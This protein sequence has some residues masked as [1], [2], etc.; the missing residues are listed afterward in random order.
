MFIH[1]LL[2]WQEPHRNMTEQAA[3]TWVFSKGKPARSWF[4]GAG[5]SDR[6][7]SPV[8]VKHTH[9]AGE[10]W[11][12]K[13][14]DTKS[15]LWVGKVNY[16]QQGNMMEQVQHSGLMVVSV[17]SWHANDL[18]GLVP[19]IASFPQS[20]SSPC[21]THTQLESPAGH[22]TEVCMFLCVGGC[23]GCQGHT[24]RAVPLV[25]CQSVSQSVSPLSSRWDPS[26]GTGGDNGSELM[27]HGG[28]EDLR[29]W[30]EKGV[31]WSNVQQVWSWTSQLFEADRRN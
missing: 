16:E 23:F 9:T 24:C 13:L 5:L 7:V 17:W 3:Q 22:V 12:G 30:P 20:N 19:M 8:K 25:R 6:L 28:S 2:F 18:E 29:G 27:R 11:Y 4:R 31:T 1:T 21:L 15:K 26:F 14:W 10:L